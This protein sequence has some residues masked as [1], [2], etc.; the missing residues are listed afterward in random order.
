MYT[1]KIAYYAKHYAKRL[2]F[3]LLCG[4]MLA[5]G[6]GGI[7]SLAGVIIGLAKGLMSYNT[8]NAVTLSA[9]IFASINSCTYTA[10][11]IGAAAGFI[12]GVFVELKEKVFFNSGFYHPPW[13]CYKKDEE[14]KENFDQ[15]QEQG[16]E[17]EEIREKEG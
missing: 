11:I 15:D 12:L 5:V 8:N 17:D 10:L 7:F 3:M 14:D 2:Y 16:E 4:V 6:L 9:S 13:T 1:Y